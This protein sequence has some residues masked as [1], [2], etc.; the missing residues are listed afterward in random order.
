MWEDIKRFWETDHAYIICKFDGGGEL[1]DSNVIIVISI[2][3][4]VF[5][6][7][8]NVADESSH[9]WR[10]YNSSKASSPFTGILLSERETRVNHRHTQTTFQ[11][12]QLPV[13]HLNGY[14]CWEG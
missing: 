11:K 1:H 6:M 10:S 8:D 3:V 2:V 4:T 13:R 7:N 12:A 9:F 5:F 14:M